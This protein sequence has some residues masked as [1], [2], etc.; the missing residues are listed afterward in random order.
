MSDFKKYPKEVQ[1]LFDKSYT[2]A[3]IMFQGKHSYGSITEYDNAW[4]RFAN[5]NSKARYEI[6]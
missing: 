4:K 3:K 5:E 1:D 2:I 6:F